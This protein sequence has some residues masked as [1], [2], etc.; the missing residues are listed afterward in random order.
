MLL[1]IEA[2]QTSQKKA[3]I[4][5]RIVELRG[6]SSSLRKGFRESNAYRRYNRFEFALVTEGYRFSRSEKALAREQPRIHLLDYQV[7]DYYQKLAGVI[8]PLPSLFNF[9]G[10]LEVEQHERTVHQTPAF[11]VKL[12]N[13]LS[14][15]LFFCEPQKLL[16]VAYVARRESGQ[17]AYYQRMLTSSRLKSIQNFINK[18]GGI[19]PNNI[20]LAF[21]DRPQFR[22]QEMPIHDNPSWL[23]WG[24]ITFPKSYRA[25][26]IID[27]QHRLYAFGGAQA[28]S[29]SHKLPVFAF[30]HLSTS[31]QASFFIEINREQKPVSPDLIWDIES[32]LRKNTHRGRIALTAKRLNQQGVLQGRIYYPLS[33]GAP[34]GKIKI[35]SIC[36]DIR[37]LQLLEDKTPHMLQSQSNP[38]T[39]GVNLQSRVQRVA[40]GI[41]EFLNAI[42]EEPEGPTY[43]DDVILKPGGI[44]LIL[45][46]YEQVLI[47]FTSPPKRGDLKDY[48]MAFVTALEHVVG[49]PGAAKAFVK[50]HL[51]SYAQRRE[52]TNQIIHHMSE[53]LDNQSF[54]QGIPPRTSLDTRLKVTE[55][56][57][58]K[59]VA[60]TLDI[61]TM[62]ELKHKTPPGVWERVE[63][64]SKSEKYTALHELFTLG[65]TKEIINRKSNRPIIMARFTDGSTGFDN[66]N[67]VM[68]ALERLIKFRNPIKHGRPVKPDKLGETYLSTFE[69]ALESI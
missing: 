5:D 28:A 23:E 12:P 26:W 11:K 32:D 40:D 13:N 47:Q 25:A 15:Y 19:F 62:K 4:R 30:E 38:L 46:A 52:V 8:G 42:L 63:A 27:G 41:N 10:E 68:V 14:G 21:T 37:D 65:E 2:T 31:R 49:G 61:H 24:V 16:E 54:V 57:L 35:S 7:F 59:L 20:I 50:N 9:L 29:G 55:R 39:H 67:E 22:S 6:K 43:R 51:T 56:K 3:S 36:N 66:G 34:R 58:A 33:G 60:E 53:L 18:D 44:T 64:R 45:T 17:E 48:A 69:S 1:V